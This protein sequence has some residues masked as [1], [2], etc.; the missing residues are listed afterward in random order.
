MNCYEF[1]YWPFT[2]NAI[3]FPANRNQSFDHLVRKSFQVCVDRIWV[4]ESG[5][6]H[7]HHGTWCMVRSCTRSALVLVAARKCAHLDAL[8][9]P[10][11]EQ[12]VQQV[13]SL[14]DFWRG[15][16]GDAGNRGD[17]LKAEMQS[18]EESLYG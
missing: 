3:N 5:F 7:R 9:V 11:W 16:C 17:I 18:L 15:E 8:L 6:Y 4:N 1:M 13:I 14:L 10:G 12:A 2:I